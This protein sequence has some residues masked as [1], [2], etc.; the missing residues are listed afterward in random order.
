[1]K[2]KTLIVY[3][4]HDS[5]KN[6]HTHNLSQEMNSEKKFIICEELSN[7]RYT[8]QSCCVTSNKMMLQSQPLSFGILHLFP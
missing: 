6:R 4:A 8:I 5:H 2:N 7:Q 3:Y 1:M